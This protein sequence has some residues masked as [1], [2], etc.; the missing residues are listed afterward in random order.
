MIEAFPPLLSV[1][2]IRVKEGE[3]SRDVQKNNPRQTLRSS[4]RLR[5]LR[6]LRKR[7]NDSRALS[8]V[9]RSTTI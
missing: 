8:R 1:P 7:V 2:I 4:R 6:A 5:S 3:M 9:L